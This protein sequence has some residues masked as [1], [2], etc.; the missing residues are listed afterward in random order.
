MKCLSVELSLQEV[1]ILRVLTRLVWVQGLEN[2]FKTHVKT[3][4][5]TELVRNTVLITDA[6]GDLFNPLYLWQLQAT[7]QGTVQALMSKQLYNDFMDI[8]STRHTMTPEIAAQFSKYN[9]VLDR[10][11]KAFLTPDEAET[12]EEVHEES[13]IVPQKNTKTYLN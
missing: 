2:N 8:L 1:E 10:V 13:S 7:E 6:Y 11:E 4:N 5:T 9:G 3:L 12:E